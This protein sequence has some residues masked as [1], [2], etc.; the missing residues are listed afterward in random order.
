MVEL[1]VASSAGGYGGP[2][3]DDEAGGD[4]ERRSEFGPVGALWPPMSSGMGIG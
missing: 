1:D 3:A 4:D 2:D